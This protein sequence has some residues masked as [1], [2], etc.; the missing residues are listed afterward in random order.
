MYLASTESGWTPMAL[1]LAIEVAG[2]M[3]LLERTRYGDRVAAVA[4]SKDLAQLLGIDPRFV[5]LSIFA[6]ASA[7][8]V[9]AGFFEMADNGIAPD[10]GFQIGLLAFAAAVLAGTRSVLWTV[11]A[12]FVLAALVQVAQISSILNDRLIWVLCVVAAILLA[13]ARRTYQRWRRVSKGE[14]VGS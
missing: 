4:S 2:L 7:L 14:D 10:M 12:S 1:V 8:A 11:A 13:G 5:Y 3:F 6:L 9:P